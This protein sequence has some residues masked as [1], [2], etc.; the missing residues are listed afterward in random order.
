[1]SQYSLDLNHI[2][3]I[4]ILPVD[5]WLGLEHIRLHWLSNAGLVIDPLLGS[6]GVSHRCQ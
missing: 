6:C 5:N 3:I 2:A 4:S 1:M